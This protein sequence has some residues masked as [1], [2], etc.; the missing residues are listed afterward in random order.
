[1]ADSTSYIVTRDEFGNDRIF[2]GCVDHKSQW[3][4]IPE[5][6]CGMSARLAMDLL[7]DFRSYDH[8]DGP[9]VVSGHPVMG[10]RVIASRDDQGR[11]V[12]IVMGC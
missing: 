8:G 5:K 4:L 7:R 9:R 12:H 11:F 10:P 2:A 1:M 3:T 6:M